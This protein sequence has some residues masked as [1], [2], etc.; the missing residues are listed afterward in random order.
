M[1]RRRHLTGPPTGY[2]TDNAA[3]PAGPFRPD[4]PT[5]VHYAAQIAINLRAALTDHNLSISAAARELD[6][7]RQTLHDILGGH[8]FPDIHTLTKAETLAGRQ[9]WPDFPFRSHDEN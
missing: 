5:A 2:L 1:P 7:S 8:T 3:W 9:L 6:L 4:T